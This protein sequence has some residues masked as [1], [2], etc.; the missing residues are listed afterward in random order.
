MV[1]NYLRV[2]QDVIQGYGELKK[3]LAEHY[4]ND[5]VAYIDAKT[6]CNYSRN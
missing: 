6:E 2:N 5:R 3:K 4:R 1:L